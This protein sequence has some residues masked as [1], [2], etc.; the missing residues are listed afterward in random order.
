MKIK[1]NGKTINLSKNDI[2]LLQEEYGTNLK[3]ILKEGKAVTIT[4]RQLSKN[5]PNEKFTGTVNAEGA[6][7]NLASESFPYQLI[8]IPNTESNID[9]L[10]E[11]RIG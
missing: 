5:H 10:K 11:F 7:I 3:N 9:L 1:K 2:N 6:I 4:L 8:E